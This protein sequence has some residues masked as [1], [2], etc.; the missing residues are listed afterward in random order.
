MQSVLRRSIYHTSLCNT[1]K[2]ILIGL[3]SL[4]GYEITETGQSTKIERC[5]DFRL[6]GSFPLKGRLCE[7][8]KC[9]QL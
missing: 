6:L 9:Q 8:R 5:G 2:S 1:F 7:Y 4:P 3:I